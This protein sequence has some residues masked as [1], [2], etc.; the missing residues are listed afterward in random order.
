MLPNGVS[1]TYD[2]D[3]AGRLSSLAH[4]RGATL[5]SNFQSSYDLS[6]NRLQAVEDVRQLVLSAGTGTPPGWTPPAQFA[7]EE[8]GYT[9]ER[10]TDGQNWI[11]VAELN[12][13]TL[14]IVSD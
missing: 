14:H 11:A 8:A 5:L 3:A 1:S 9:L 13:N 10:S 12:A 6:G 7:V 2:F 4:H